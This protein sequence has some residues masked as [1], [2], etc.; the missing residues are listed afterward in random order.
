MCISNGGGRGGMVSA[1]PVLNWFHDL[2]C[3]F[4]Q[5]FFSDDYTEDIDQ[6]KELTREY[7]ESNSELIICPDMHE[8][9]PLWK[10]QEGPGASPRFRPNGTVDYPWHAWLAS[11]FGDHPIPIQPPLQ[12]ENQKFDVW[13]AYVLN[14]DNFC[15]TD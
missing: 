14:L 4:R 11:E 8:H 3:P 5:R 1:D 10:V 2:R 9:G 15:G 7:V 6:D 13:A 12:G